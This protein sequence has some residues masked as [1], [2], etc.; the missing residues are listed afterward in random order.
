[1]YRADR[2]PERALPLF[3]ETFRLRRAR[4]GVDHPETLV[5]MSNLAAAYRAVGRRDEALPLWEEALRLGRGR[6]GPGHSTTLN[7][8][9]N[10]AAGYGAARRPDRALPLLIEAAAGFERRRFRDGPAGRTIG[11]P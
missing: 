10:L 9:D 6:L 11:H 2:K 8:M 4:Q 5:S 7:L 1:T 3:E